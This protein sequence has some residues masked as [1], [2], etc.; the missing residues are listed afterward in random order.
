M[1]EFAQRRSFAGEVNMTSLV[2]VFFLLLQQCQ[3]VRRRK[4]TWRRAAG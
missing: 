4:S 2:D 1:L 3:H